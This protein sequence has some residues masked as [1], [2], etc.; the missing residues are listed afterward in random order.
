MKERKR[1]QKE[2]K[3]KEKSKFPKGKQP[4]QQGFVKIPKKSRVALR[5]SG[6]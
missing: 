6:R 2:E 4:T 1:K 5:T 3:K